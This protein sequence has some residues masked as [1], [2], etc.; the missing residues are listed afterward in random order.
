MNLTIINRKP[1]H[2]NHSW[3]FSIPMILMPNF[4][5]GT[6]YAVHIHNDRLSIRINLK[7]HQTKIKNKPW[8]VH[9]FPIPIHVQRQ[10]MEQERFALEIAL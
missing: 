1:V 4:T 2:S 9:Y 7:V 3:R 6:F 10:F 8:D 5:V